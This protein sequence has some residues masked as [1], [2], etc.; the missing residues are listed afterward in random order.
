LKFGNTA[1]R[2]SRRAA[3]SFMERAME[4]HSS[5]AFVG[6]TCTSGKPGDGKQS[7]VN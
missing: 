7:Q 1:T 2:P 5:I 3:Q 4:C 6:R